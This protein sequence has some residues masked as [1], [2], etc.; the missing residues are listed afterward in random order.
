MLYEFLLGE[1]A[2]LVIYFGVFLPMALLFRLLKRDALQLQRDP[3]AA[4]YWQTKKQ[5]THVASYYRPS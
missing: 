1:I 3:R 4:T 5:P 2:L